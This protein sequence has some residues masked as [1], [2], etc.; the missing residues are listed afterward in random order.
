[1]DVF[2]KIIEDVMLNMYLL[3]CHRPVTGILVVSLLEYD[4][5]CVCLLSLQVL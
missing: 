3:Q 5:I 2:W 1:M 4:F